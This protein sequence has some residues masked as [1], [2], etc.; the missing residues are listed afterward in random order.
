MR[1]VS[2][3]FVSVDFNFSE[4]ELFQFINRGLAVP[5]STASLVRSVGFTEG[6]QAG[7]PNS[8]RNDVLPVGLAKIA[9]SVLWK[10]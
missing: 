10:I 2:R 8:H 1:F 9:V 4:S 5:C 6:A 3:T 7:V